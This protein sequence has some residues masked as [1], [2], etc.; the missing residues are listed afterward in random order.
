MEHPDSSTSGRAESAG[1]LFPPNN[2]L[3][4]AV[5]PSTSFSSTSTLAFPMQSSTP[6]TSIA[7]RK[8]ALFEK[9]GVSRNG[10]PANKDSSAV[11]SAYLATPSFTQPDWVRLVAERRDRKDTSLSVATT[12][13]AFSGT[14]PT[15]AKLTPM[16]TGSTV[17][18]STAELGLGHP[19]QPYPGPSA[20][21]ITTLRRSS[22]GSKVKMAVMAL[23]TMEKVR[24]AEGGPT[25]RVGAPPSTSDRDSRP[26]TSMRS[27]SRLSGTTA[28]LAEPELQTSF[29]M[30]SELSGRGRL[31]SPDDKESDTERNPEDRG[32][33]PP[34]SDD[35]IDSSTPG[36]AAPHPDLVVDTSLAANF[37]SYSLESIKDVEDETV[38]P[39]NQTP[40][41]IFD[42]NF[43][44]H[45]PDMVSPRTGLAYV[46][47]PPWARARSDDREPTLVKPSQYRL[48]RKKIAEAHKEASEAQRSEPEQP[49]RGVQ[50]NAATDAPT[51]LDLN[52][53]SPSTTTQPDSKPPSPIQ[54]VNCEPDERSGMQEASPPHSPGASPVPPPL[55]QLSRSTTT[56]IVLRGEGK[57][58]PIPSK[59]HSTA[60][61]HGSRS[62]TTT[63]IRTVSVSNSPTPSLNR[64]RRS[65]AMTP[66]PIRPQHTG[67]Q[68]TK[69]WQPPER[70]SRPDSVLSVSLPQWEDP[71][72]VKAHNKIPLRKVETPGSGR[73]AM[74]FSVAF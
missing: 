49:A 61:L 10:S 51:Q 18:S 5:T 16:P 9:I 45:P 57:R 31:L 43:D 1:L 8:A 74:R 32:L 67:L 11:N 40:A 26:G 24:Q 17:V 50:I 73:K 56:P 62:S 27:W 53:K 72:E 29:P 4:N 47:L 69:F 2:R 36:Y 19:S 68:P 64:I 48:A 13:T 28:A 30:D 54:E 65:S 3:S 38:E 55:A 6:L 21:D 12:S 33:L 42:K 41:G 7:A 34:E 71:V 63:H 59:R 39:N 25:W 44:T 14:Q 58:L 46:I 66:A 70:F 37:A 60:L 35:K 20:P 52:D 15:P 23:N 22:A